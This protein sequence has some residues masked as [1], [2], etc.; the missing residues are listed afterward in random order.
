ML[1]YSTILCFYVFLHAGGR[2]ASDNLVLTSTLDFRRCPELDSAR[3]AASCL[4]C[5]DYLAR[6]GIADLSKHDVTAIKP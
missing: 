4:N 2:A 1:C 3:L 6:L 5:L